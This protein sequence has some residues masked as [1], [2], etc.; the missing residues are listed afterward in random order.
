[1]H[2]FVNLFSNFGVILVSFWCHF[3]TLGGS[4]GVCWRLFATL[5][6]P[7]APLRGPSRKS[8][9]NVGSFTALWGPLEVPLETNFDIFCV[10]SLLFLYVFLK[11][12][13]KDFR[14]LGG[15]TPTVKTVVSSTRNHC[16]HISSWSSKVTE[17]CV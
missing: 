11:R 8:N 2:S 3:G 12:F 13:F 1:L 7:R 17:N 6:L 14:S 10:F 15:P 5:G 4:F 9:E 16:F